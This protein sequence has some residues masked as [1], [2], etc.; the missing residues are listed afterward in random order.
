MLSA[1]VC[2]E[3]FAAP[4]AEAVLAA[5]HAVAGPAGVVLVVTN[6]TGDRLCFGQAAE[7]AHAAGVAIE[8]GCAS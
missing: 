1:A 4:S 8:V 3:V 5:I 2:G 7:Q 6:Y